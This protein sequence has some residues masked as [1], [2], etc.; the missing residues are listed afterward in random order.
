MK[1]RIFII[2]DEVAI[3][4]ML[5]TL[6]ESRGY[7]VFT[8]PR[9]AACTECLLENGQNCADILL[10]DVTMPGLSGI[11]FLD[12]QRRV[13]CQISN[14]ALMSGNWAPEDWATCR[15]WG[16]LTLVKPFRMEAIADWLDACVK[17]ISPDQIL[18]DCFLRQSEQQGVKP[19]QPDSVCTS[20]DLPRHLDHSS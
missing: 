8:F 3:R 5:K 18:F 13:G 16:Y 4:R 1:P 10:I 17:R 11:E 6:S 7:E 2:D 19:D 15:R 14:I 9:A 20:S 12:S